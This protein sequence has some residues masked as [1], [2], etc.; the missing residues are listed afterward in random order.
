MNRRPASSSSRGSRLP[1]GRPSEAHKE[2]FNAIKAVSAELFAR[3]GYAATDLREI[4]DAVDIHVSSLY[5]Y[6]FGKEHLLYEIMSDGLREA[7]ACLDE[8][9]STSSRPEEQLYAAIRAHVLHHAHRSHLAWSASIEE[10]NL[11]GDYLDAILKMKH[12]F[13]STFLEVLTRGMDEGVL[14]VTNPKIVLYGLIGMAQTVSR[15]YDPNG[16]LTAEE[17]ADILANSAMFGLVDPARSKL[18][19]GE[20]PASVRENQDLDPERARLTAPADASVDGV[21]A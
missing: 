15:W 3:Q 4:A 5:N 11:T 8:A 7:N 9:L 2:R 17:I 12:Q 20:S 10:R 6:I 21:Q 16:S 13:E 14:R 19:L 18:R 1:R